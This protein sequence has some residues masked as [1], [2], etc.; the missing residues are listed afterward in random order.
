MSLLRIE[1]KQRLPKRRERVMEILGNALAS[2]LPFASLAYILEKTSESVHFRT[3]NI[4]PTF[5]FS[6][7]GKIEL[8]EDGMHTLL[9]LRM[10]LTGL[11][12]LCY[13]A[14]WIPAIVLYVLESLWLSLF[15]P[16]GVS[17]FQGWTTAV[18]LVWPFLLFLGA[19]RL[20][21]FRFR[22]FLHNLVYF[23]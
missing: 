1:L 10:D 5:W 22:A 15:S 4:F 21:L 8:E 20:F 14:H 16:E 17:L 13:A 12:F 23:K 7:R 19:R 9:R 6:S 3:V 11:L 2:A 18:L